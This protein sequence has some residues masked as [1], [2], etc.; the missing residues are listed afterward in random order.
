MTNLLREEAKDFTWETMNQI[1]SFMN[2]PWALV[3]YFIV[4][5]LS[6]LQIITMSCHKSILLFRKL[7]RNPTMLCEQNK[8]IRRLTKWSN[9]IWWQMTFIVQIKCFYCILYQ[10]KTIIQQFQPA[11]A[12]PKKLEV[13]LLV[14]MPF[15]LSFAT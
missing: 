10:T 15:K 14:G 1:F 11:K 8:M 2:I 5:Y 9:T 4:I 6:G 13:K 12:L 7:F 3:S